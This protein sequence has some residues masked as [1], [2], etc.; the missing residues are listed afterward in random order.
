MDTGGLGLKIISVPCSL[1]DLGL[2][3]SA[4]A[5]HLPPLSTEP[6]LGRWGYV[7]SSALVCSKHSAHLVRDSFPLGTVPLKALLI[8]SFHSILWLRVPWLRAHT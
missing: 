6:L 4:F 5:C 8:T 7:R 3:A 2:L 1:W